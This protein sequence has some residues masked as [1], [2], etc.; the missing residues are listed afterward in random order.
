[1]IS[2][3]QIDD[4]KKRLLTIKRE[5]SMKSINTFVNSANLISQI[6]EDLYG[7][8]RA[9]VGKLFDDFF[10][11]KFSKYRKIEQDAINCYN[12]CKE[13]TIQDRPAH[14]FGEAFYS[15]VRCKL[16]HSARSFGFAFAHLADMPKHQHLEKIS[17]N[18][19]DKILL[20][21]E[22][23]L[24]EIEQVIDEIQKSSYFDASS[25]VKPLT[26]EYDAMTH[27]SGSPN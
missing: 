24:V 21:A 17:Y 2:K 5:T 16:D 11:R 13:R 19:T 8:G 27:V 26:I 25:T 10:K 1:M 7:P 4:Y 20:I 15:G 3:L 9:S 22:P 14:D 6:A 23:F 12:S 18:G